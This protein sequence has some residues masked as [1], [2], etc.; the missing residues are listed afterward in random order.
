MSAPLGR[1]GRQ[2]PRPEVNP[3]GEGEVHHMRQLHRVIRLAAAALAA[4]LLAAGLS[5]CGGSS[6]SSGSGS[7]S[8]ATSAAVEA[9]AK[10]VVD[11]A[12]KP[13][14]TFDGPTVPP[15]RPPAGKQLAV[16]Y[17]VPAPLPQ[18][19]SQSVVDAAKA[20]GWQAHLIDGKGTP[21]GYVDA[22]DQAI[23]E[24]VDGIVLVAMPAELLQREI[25]AAHAAGIPVVAAL[26]GTA[27]PVAPETLGLF[28]DVRASYEDQG[29]ALAD[30]VIADAPHGA[31]VIRLESPEFGDLTKESRVFAST[32]AAAGPQYKVVDVV[33]SPVTDILGGPDGVQRIAAAL[34]S[35]PDA[36]Y[37]FT[38]S[39]SWSQIFRQAKKLVGSTDVVGLGSDGDVS[40]PLV[41]QGEPLVMIGPDSKTYGWYAVDALIRAFNGK[42]A[43]H[44]RVRSHLVDATNAKQEGGTGITAHYD[45]RSAWERL[46]GV[47]R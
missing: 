41:A 6:T 20:V 40:V 42:P 17:P 46:W 9:Q 32:L 2:R 13:L 7:G 28:D 10:Q 29:K 33:S 14:T 31:H 12:R 19:A 5:A 25:A 37:V 21:K 26:P 11:A 30:W 1:P 16:I 45:Y 18:N 22:M 4:A 34:R 47:G 15:G 44:Y 23:S 3:F 43:V 27:N 36:K 24:K 38:L 8:A 35:N 39:E